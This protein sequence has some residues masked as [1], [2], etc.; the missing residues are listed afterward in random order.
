MRE[1][2][3]TEAKAH[4]AQLLNSVGHGETITIT[5]HGRPVVHLVPARAQG[6][7]AR[8]AA[9]HGFEA[10]RAKWK[11]TGMSGEEILAARDDGRRY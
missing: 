7:A 11:R 6:P 1:V 2:P 3:A 4:A 5:R 10:Q 9:G 8:R